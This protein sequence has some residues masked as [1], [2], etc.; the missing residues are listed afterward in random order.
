MTLLTG[1]TI[2]SSSGF[3]DDV[4]VGRAAAVLDTVR[5][6]LGIPLVDDEKVSR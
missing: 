6:M 3:G 5:H 2:A 4:D 1:G